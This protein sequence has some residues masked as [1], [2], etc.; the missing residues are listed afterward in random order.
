MTRLFEISAFRLIKVIPGS[1]IYESVNQG[2]LI[3]GFEAIFPGKDQE[4]T[5]IWLRAIQDPVNLAK[6]ASWLQ[7]IVEREVN[8]R[9][10]AHHCELFQKKVTIGDLLPEHGK[11]VTP[12]WLAHL[13]AHT[14]SPYAVRCRTHLDVEPEN[15]EYK[16]G[17][18]QNTANPLEFLI[19]FNFPTRSEHLVAL[20]GIVIDYLDN[21]VK[22][23]PLRGLR[24]RLREQSRIFDRSRLYT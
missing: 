16:E 12:Y 24:S 22:G 15:F 19:A 6:D 13:I 2:G 11:F 3:S 23:I 4:V 14:I 1:R 7:R 21:W 8:S 10:I 18:R 17:V 9:F 20:I 5:V